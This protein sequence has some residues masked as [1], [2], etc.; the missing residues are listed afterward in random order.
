MG[1]LGLTSGILDAYAYGNALVRHLKN[2][3]S[4]D[5]LTR[6][7][8]SRRRVWHDFTD[9]TS[10]AN[11]VRLIAASEKDVREREVFFQRLQADP[12]FPTVLRKKMDDM[13]PETFAIS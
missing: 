2:G 5:I 9:P 12:S 8:N 3:E 4:D 7:A 13:M 6:C 10:E 11:Y 1:G